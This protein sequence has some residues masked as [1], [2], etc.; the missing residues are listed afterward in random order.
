MLVP[1]AN[2][3]SRQTSSI[4]IARQDGAR[5]CA[6]DCRH[7]SSHNV[8]A[9]P[10]PA[11]HRRPRRLV[12]RLRR[13]GLL[14]GADTGLQRQEG[15]TIWVEVSR[16][17]VQALQLETASDDS[18]VNR[19]KSALA[20]AIKVL[21]RLAE[22]W[23]NINSFIRILETLSSPLQPEARLPEST[24]PMSYPS[25]PFAMGMGSTENPLGNIPDPFGGDFSF[26]FETFGINPDA[27]WAFHNSIPGSPTFL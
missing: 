7:V 23:S 27:L 4:T 12:A 1:S 20:K 5:A 16:I 21:S 10:P 26:D 9:S 17:G 8:Y 3:R 19:S 13:H 22:R 15:D 25:N 24:L 2:Y 14:L 11:L 18:E 6:S